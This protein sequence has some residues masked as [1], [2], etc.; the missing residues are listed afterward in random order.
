MTSQ[1]KILAILRQE[2]YRVE[3]GNVLRY[4]QIE[5][6]F[7]P[8]ISSGG[9]MPLVK[10]GSVV[11]IFLWEDV[12]AVINGMGKTIQEKNPQSPKQKKRIPPTKKK[13]NVKAVKKYPKGEERARLSPDEL[14]FINQNWQKISINK[15]ALKFGVS[16]FVVSHHVRKIKKAK[17]H[18][19]N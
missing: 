10:K 12:E 19:T 17:I 13:N 7:K 1:E 14:M 9:R 8:V 4:D 3:N 11:E 5:D 6:K 18:D 2:N 15:M 16:R